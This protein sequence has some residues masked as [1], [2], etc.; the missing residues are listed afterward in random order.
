MNR[1][2]ATHQATIVFESAGIPLG[3]CRPHQFENIHRVKLVLA[4]AAAVVSHYFTCLVAGCRYTRIYTKHCHINY[5]KPKTVCIHLY[6]LFYLVCCI[7][8]LAVFFWIDFG[9]CEVLLF[10]NQLLDFLV[11]YHKLNF[12][13]C[14]LNIFCAIVL[15]WIN[16]LL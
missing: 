16:E 15:N 13:K 6:L 14:K 11:S 9:E 2:D 8:W 10:W 5:Y 12:L 4:R 7:F 3:G 1:V